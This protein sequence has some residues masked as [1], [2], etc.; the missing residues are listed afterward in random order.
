M[1]EGRTTFDDLI[2]EFLATGAAKRWQFSR[3]ELNIDAGGAITATNV[4]GEFHC[5][6]E[7]PMFGNGCAPPL[8]TGNARRSW[9]AR[10]SP[11]RG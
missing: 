8:N 1:R 6:T 2:T 5:F 9:T 7:V 4:G 11:P 3:P 10:C